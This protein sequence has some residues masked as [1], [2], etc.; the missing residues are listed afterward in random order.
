MKIG[1]LEIL[2]KIN[3]THDHAP[4]YGKHALKTSIIAVTVASAL[5]LTVFADDNSH[6]ISSHGIL[7]YDQNSDGTA[8]IELNGAEIQNLG[9]A[10]NKQKNDLESAK[11]ALTDI[12]AKNEALENS[13]DD[14]TE[15]V[16]G[17]ASTVQGSLANNGVCM[18]T[19]GGSSKNENNYKQALASASSDYNSTA[20]SGSKTNSSN[21]NLSDSINCI[22]NIGK[23]PADHSDNVVGITA[24]SDNDLKD[25]TTAHPD[26]PTAEQK[27]AGNE[28]GI[29]YTSQLMA[30]SGAWMADD[31]GLKWY[32]GTTVN[33]GSSKLYYTNTGCS[34]T[35]WTSYGGI[36]NASFSDPIEIQVT[37]N[38]NRIVISGTSTNGQSIYVTGTLK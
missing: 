34:L 23:L 9:A 17:L 13:T 8:E 11:T 27:T 2:V 26:A 12:Q 21:L 19:D 30:G 15:K 20:Y 38:E 18:N 29:N 35:G 24:L 14:L 33:K 16:E 32:E 1:N 10:A 25:F 7:K 5:T 31:G 3:H 36:Q 28:K 4:H 37:T 6:G 22:N